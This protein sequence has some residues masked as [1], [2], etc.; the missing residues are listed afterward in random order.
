[1]ATSTTSPDPARL[2]RDAAAIAAAAKRLA[3]ALAD[4]Q[5]DPPP[6]AGRQTPHNLV[7]VYE[8]AT[9]ANVSVT[10]VSQWQK[11]YADFPKPLVVLKCG[12]VFDGFAVHAW[13]LGRLSGKHPLVR[14]ARLGRG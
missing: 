5:Q 2:A 3:K 9:I 8:I 4:A 11:R 10:A 1:M 14:S 12:P 7:G 6:A 13:L